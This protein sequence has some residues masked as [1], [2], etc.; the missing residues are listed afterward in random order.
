MGVVR[1]DAGPTYVRRN[2]FLESWMEP[3]AP[4]PSAIAYDWLWGYL[5]PVGFLMLMWGSIPRRRAHR[6]TPIAA[7]SIA[8]AVLGYWAVGFALHMGGA[9][10]VTQE[11][12]LLGLQAMLSLVPGDPGWGAMGLS[13]FFLIGDAITPEVLRLFLA[14]LPIIAT[15]VVLVS[16]SLAQTRRWIMAM[17]AVLT[18]TIIVP[19]AACWMWG[20][21]WLSHIGETM[22]LAKGF[23]DFGGSTLMLW[24][25]GMM[26]LPI[27]LLQ[28]R[29][30]TVAAKPPANHAPLVSNIG[31]VIMGIG[32]LGWS[33]A[34]PF[35]VN[36]AVLD[37]FRVAI[38]VLLGMAGA[39]VTSQLYGW[40][41]TGK[42]ETL[43]AAQG[44]AAG[45][46]TVLA[47]APF[48]PV[49]AALVIG[50]LA[51][52][53]FPAF[54]YAI[55]IG[56][57]IQD[58]ATPVALALTSGLPGVL[59]L[60]FL[61]D[62]QWG[63]GWNRV[64]VMP[65]GAVTGVGVVGLFVSG[66]AQQLSAQLIGL[67]AVGVWGLLW[68]SL[69]GVIASPRIF[70]AVS[71][72]VRRAEIA[73]G[74]TETPEAPLSDEASPSIEA[75]PQAPPPDDATPPTE[76]LIPGA[77]PVPAPD[78]PVVTE[79]VEAPWPDTIPTAPADAPLDENEQQPS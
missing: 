4:L 21:G 70:G 31:A 27:L 7:M 78:T 23:V 77:E 32:W 48:V 56:F 75:A 72:R 74:S 69:L 71:R 14:Y 34:Q 62:G 24:L 11:A 60:A 63:Q 79:E 1:P 28:G 45:W 36:G 43:L 53:I 58:A 66:S 35:H 65:D 37:W 13:G 22:G 76:A 40:L 51:G 33:L 68:G 5:I 55:T 16:G 3:I 18:G 6:V 61:A 54:H 15:A 64:G 67:V 50:L 42:P 10:P 19:I 39:V 9:Y 2:P 29:P 44:L 38:N 26:V 17:A 52:L 20:S 47:C 57:R 59:G 46:G 12:E 8:V 30:R 25:P 41:V 49:W 73:S